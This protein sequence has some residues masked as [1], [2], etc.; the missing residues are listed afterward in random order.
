MTR[1][2]PILQA[3]LALEDLQIASPCHAR[4]EDMRGDER[5]RELM[6]NYNKSLEQSEMQLGQNRITGRTGVKPVGA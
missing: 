1:A 2:L 6:E 5:F 4:W 3:P